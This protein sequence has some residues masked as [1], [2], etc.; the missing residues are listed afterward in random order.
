MKLADFL[1]RL[2]GKIT[3]LNAISARFDILQ[4]QLDRLLSIATQSNAGFTALKPLP[5]KDSEANGG[6]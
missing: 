5:L 2:R 1:K 6:G 3:G 4:M